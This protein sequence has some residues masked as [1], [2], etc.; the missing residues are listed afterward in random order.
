ML[1]FVMK[2][3]YMHDVIASTVANSMDNV[4]YVLVHNDDANNSIT[5]EIK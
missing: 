4:P 1:I 5:V 3:E 2:L